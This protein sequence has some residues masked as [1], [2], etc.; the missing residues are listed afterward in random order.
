MRQLKPV[1]PQRKALKARR[2]L[3]PLAESLECRDL[4]ATLAPI[5]D[6]SVPADLGRPVVLEGAA[7]N[8]TFTA[9]SSNANVRATVITGQ[10]LQIDVTHASSGASDPAFSGVLTF[11][12]FDELT[13][14][15][16][17]RILT[18]VNQGFYTSP[19][20]NTSSSFTN[21][22]NKNF[23]RVASG[24]PGDEFIVQGGSLNGNGTGEIDQP[25]FPFADEF[26]RSLVF[27]GEGQLAMANAGDDTNSSQFFITTGQPRFLDF[28]HTIFGQ[29]VS[30]QAVLDQMTQV[31]RDSN[32][33][34]ISPILM[35]GTVVRGANP[36]GVVLIDTGS[37][38]A[39]ATANVTVTAT[40]PADNT[41]ASRTFRV[42]VVANTNDE[43]PFLGPV[44]NQVVGVNQ[45]SRFTLTA[46]STDPGDVLT[47]RVAG[48]LNAAGTAFTDVQNATATVD[49]QGNV[50][51]T[52]TAGFSGTIN[53]L[54]GV[55][56]QNNRG[57]GTLDSPSNFDTQAIT[58]SVTSNTVPT[59]TP[60]TVTT[61]QNT[62]IAIQL[63][64]TSGDP[65][66]GQTITFAPASQPVNGRI[67]EFNTTTGTLTYIP[68]VNF[69]GTDTFTFTVSDVGE[70]LPNLT[71]QPATVTINVT[72][73]QEENV[74]PTV[75]PIDQTVIANTPIG[76]Q[77]I[78][79]PGNVTQTLNYQLNTQGTRGTITDFNTT[80]GTFTYTPPNGF[81]G[82]DTLTY[83]ATDV[84][85]PLPNLTSQP[86]TITL[87]VVGDS[88][89]GAVRV[90]NTTLLISPLPGRRR[91]PSPNTIDVTIVG[92]Q[93]VT[94]V[95]GIIDST[96]PEVSAIDR[97]VVYGS[98]ARDVIT[99][100][101]QVPQLSTL[102]GGLGGNNRI[103]SNDSPSRLHGWFGRNNL[104]GGESDDALIGRIGRVRFIQSGGNDLLFAGEPARRPTGLGDP[105]HRHIRAPIGQFFRFVNG[106]LVRR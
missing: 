38:S 75:T 56:D 16:V 70:P 21:L 59:A 36:N 31:A 80:A 74:P 68:N 85:P 86:A 78:G 2:A 4:L 25:G 81:I 52:P 12:L 101:P 94:T 64:G 104:G 91:N 95:N 99:V 62:S 6:V 66:S 3:Q 55:R 33:A 49:S 44:S 9:T 54:V 8:Q 67:T 50:T 37:A 26:V 106:R 48:G 19:T 20:E 29:L 76:I 89:T 90:I 14:T 82:T 24:F 15:T 47:F 103:R 51:V 100:A 57:G 42:D 1:G 46:V 61:P 53:L 69:V 87:S 96:R 65:S 17:S 5:N 28:Q 79:N 83:T 35:T 27:T 102:D 58:L 34:P 23:H 71:S 88:P 7:A 41:T 40:D 97:V 84:G 77:L 18:L 32:D 73:G 105:D 39:G 10:F 72:Q 45:T 60:I 93:L 13:P 98:K 30:G 92:S 43:R 22:P 11:Q 63:A